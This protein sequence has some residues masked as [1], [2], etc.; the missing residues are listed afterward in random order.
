[1]KTLRQVRF[2]D[3]TIVAGSTC[4]CLDDITESI[5]TTTGP[6]WFACLNPHSQVIA[7]DDPA[8]SE[9]LHAV[10]WLVPDGV[11]VVLASRFL[12][13]PVPERITGSDVFHGLND[14]LNR[15]GGGSIF[16]LGS[17]DRILAEIRRCMA[18]DYPNL[19]VAGTFSP[20]YKPEFS[21]TELNE[22]IAAINAVKPDVLWVGMTAPKQEKWIH[23]NRHR[24]QVKFIGAIGAVFDFYTGRV[25]RS[26][27]VFHKLGLEWLPRLLQ[28]PRRLW[29]R[30]GISAPLFVAEVVGRKLR[31]KP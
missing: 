1:M 20:P 19:R 2:L 27:P 30:M 4:D 14:R 9:A 28:E 29:R 21:V 11:G 12:G 10:D 25:K 31:R 15:N 3:Y 26:H 7:K 5:A 17:T 22:M 23:Q 8:F 16:F 18:M 6:R 24:L 13:C